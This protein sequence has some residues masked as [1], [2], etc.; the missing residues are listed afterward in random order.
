MKKNLFYPLLIVIASSSY[1]VLSTIVKVAMQHGFTTGEAVSS[2]YIIGFML[3][4]TI[5]IVTQRQLP[6]L[7]KRDCLFWC[8]PGYLPELQELYTA[9]H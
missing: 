9:N 6:K 4:A 8:V 7:S 2:Q 5:F 1:G 3:V